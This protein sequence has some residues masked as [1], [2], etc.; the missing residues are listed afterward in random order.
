VNRREKLLAG[1][2]GGLVGVFAL[3]MGYRGVILKPLQAEDRKTAS[4]R[5]KLEKVKAERRAYFAAEDE[6]RKFTLRT[7]DTDVDQASAKSA[8]M[9]THVILQA[10]LPET[11]FSRLPAGPQKLRGAMEL[12]WSVSG[13]GR[14]EQ[15]VNLLFLLQEE[16]HAHRIDGLALTPGETPGSVRVRFRY[17]TLVVE[18]APEVEFAPLPAKF[19]LDSPERQLYAGILQRDILRPYI[20]RQPA[21]PGTPPP[22]A[23]PPSTPGAPPGPETLRVVSLS[24][25]QGQ[26][27]VHIRDLANQRT[28]RYRPGDALAGGVVAL[29]DYRAMPL[30]GNEGLQSFSRVILKIGDDYWAVERGRTLAEKYR[31][32]P[33][34]LPATLAKTAK[35]P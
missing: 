34:Q 20:K 26:P 3:G 5:E 9:L 7:F 22:A 23:P 17:L 8:E 16:P 6:V 18:P 24:E 14:L 21:P 11:D 25:W 33:E 19:T 35:A 13:E 4:L 27:E 30:P 1:A 15:I 2:V 31:L 12:G 28:L 10:G 29:V 32:K